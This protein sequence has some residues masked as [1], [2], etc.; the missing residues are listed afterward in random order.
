MDAD[1]N[2]AVMIA[3]VTGQVIGLVAVLLAMGGIRGIADFC[4][5]CINQVIMF[6]EDPNDPDNYWH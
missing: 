4:Q 1:L 2:F 3:E 5:W 6:F